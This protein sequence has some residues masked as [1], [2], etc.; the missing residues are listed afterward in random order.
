MGKLHWG[1]LAIG[2]VLGIV[3]YM[4]LS[5]RKRVGQSSS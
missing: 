3:V 5:G 2:A 1:S 4:F